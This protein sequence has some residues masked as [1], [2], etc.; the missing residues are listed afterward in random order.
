MFEVGDAFPEKAYPRIDDKETLVYFLKRF[1][2]LEDIVPLHSKARLSSEKKLAKEAFS[3]WLVPT[4]MIREYYG[5]ETTM[6][7][8]WMNFFISI[9][10]IISYRVAGDSWR[11]CCAYQIA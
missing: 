6:Y 10:N 1:N 7:F 9:Y 4:Q 8:E 2:F 3:H 11:L 5:D